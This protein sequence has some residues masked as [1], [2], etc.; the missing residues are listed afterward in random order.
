MANH[1]QFGNKVKGFLGWMRSTPMEEAIPFVRT[2]TLPS[3]TAATPVSVIAD[4]EVPAGYTPFVTDFLGRVNGTTAWAT[5][6]TVK[7]QDT[8]GTP[9]DFATI[10]VAALTSQARLVKGTANVTLEDAMSL[11]TGGTASKGIQVKANANGTGSD[12]VLTVA[13]FYRKS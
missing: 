3:A 13:G 8:N 11:G 12:L 2:V 4:A 9:V 1:T 7:L 5:T 10:A 6:A